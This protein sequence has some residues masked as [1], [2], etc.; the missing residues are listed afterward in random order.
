MVGFSRLTVALHI[1]HRL[2]YVE[3]YPFKPKKLYHINCHPTLNC[4]GRESYLE[5][6]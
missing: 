3:Y 6:D 5:Y 1:E 2:R 4:Q